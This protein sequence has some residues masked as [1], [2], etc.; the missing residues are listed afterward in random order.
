M[1]DRFSRFVKLI[2]LPVITASVIGMAIRNNWLMQFGC[3]E[4][5]LSDRGSYFT[6]LVFNILNKFYGIQQLFT[7]SYHPQ[8]NGRLERFH[9]YLMQRLRILAHEWKYDFVDTDDW[10]EFLP[11]IAFSYNNNPN[12]MTGYSPY[13]CIYGNLIRLTIDNILKCNDN[14][15]I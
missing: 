2:P 5:L 4:N 6:G 10:D 11:N 14:S 1:M 7:T 15:D 9:R 12:R 3:P 8:C 13:Q